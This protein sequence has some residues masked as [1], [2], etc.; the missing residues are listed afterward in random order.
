MKVLLIGA[1][2][3]IGRAVHQRLGQQHE[4]LTA[5]RHSGQFRVDITDQASVR[6]LLAEVGPIDALVS[7]TGDVHFGPLAEMT[8]EQFN[9]GLQGK[10]LGQV[11][12]A[13]LG[14]HVLRNGGSITLTAGIVSREPIRLGANATAVNAAIEGFAR[15]AA[16]ELPRG[17]RINVVSP[18]VLTESLAAYGPYMPGMESVPAER[19]ALAYQR[20]VEG[21]QTGRTYF[22]E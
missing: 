5:G 12:L 10:L 18:A 1:S 11:R 22:V 14:Q 2:G 15:G 3:A 6:R 13:L 19:V 17:M 20:S 16:I 9:V 21:A 7:T 8:D 4:V